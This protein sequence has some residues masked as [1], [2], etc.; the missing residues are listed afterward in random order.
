MSLEPNLNHMQVSAMM[1]KFEQQ[2]ESL[3]VQASFMDAAMSSTTTMT[4]PEVGCS[5][6]LHF[7]P[8]LRSGASRSAD[9]G[10]RRRARVRQPFSV[11]FSH[12]LILIQT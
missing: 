5:N 10:G 12:E 11:S 4:T 2:F 3:D 1:A 9:L 8:H 6:F 7:C